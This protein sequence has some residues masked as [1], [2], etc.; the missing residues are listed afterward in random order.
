MVIKYIQDEVSLG[1]MIGL[2]EFELAT[3]VHTSPFGVIPRGHTG[4]WRLT[5]NLSSPAG[6]SVNDGIDP[7]SCLLTY[8]G[9]YSDKGG[10]ET[11]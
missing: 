1:R 8:L 10:G 5:V 2:L 11:R 7:T 6:S 4:K 3:R 9:R